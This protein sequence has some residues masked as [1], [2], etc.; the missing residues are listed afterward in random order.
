MKKLFFALALIAGM[1]FS[2]QLSAQDDDPEFTLELLQKFNNRPKSPSKLNLT[3]HYHNGVLTF[4]EY[5]YNF[6]QVTVTHLATG[7]TWVDVVTP[8]NPHMTIGTMPGT[9][10]ISTETDGH[11]FFYGEITI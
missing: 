10:T 1:Y 5:A 8:D 9:Y 3:G 2:E 6:M 11:Q 7:Q 4:G